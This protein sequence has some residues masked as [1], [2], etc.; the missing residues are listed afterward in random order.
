LNDALWH[1]FGSGRVVMTAAV[2]AL[3]TD[4]QANQ[5]KVITNVQ[6]F[7]AFDAE[8]ISTMSTTLAASMSAARRSFG[9]SMT[10]STDME[11]GSPEMGQMLI[12]T[13]LLRITARAHD[14]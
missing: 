8:T 2:A 3:P 12:G 11:G 4:V 10:I 1:T 14:A 9:R 13:K 5:A 6:S 7:D